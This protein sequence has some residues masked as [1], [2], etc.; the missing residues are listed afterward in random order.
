MSALDPIVTFMGR[1]PPDEYEQR[2]RLFVARNCGA[3]KATN[4]DNAIARALAWIVTEI[5]TERVFAPASVDELAEVAE[6]LLILLN[7]ADRA[8]LVGAGE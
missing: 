5:A 2:R 7:C 6:L 3:Y 1:I 4:T 8:D